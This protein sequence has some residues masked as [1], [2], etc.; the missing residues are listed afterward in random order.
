MLQPVASTAPDTMPTGLIC[1]AVRSM[2]SFTYPVGV[3]TVAALAWEMAT[4]APH[5]AA[6]AAA[7]TFFKRIAPLRPRMKRAPGTLPD[8][9]KTSRESAS[10]SHNP[11]PGCWR[12]EP[13]R[14]WPGPSRPA[15]PRAGVVLLAAGMALRGPALASLPDRTRPGD[16]V[17]GR[18]PAPSAPRPDRAWPRPAARR[19]RAVRLGGRGAGGRRP[20][21][22]DVAARAAAVESP[23]LPHRRLG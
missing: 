7:R 2:P 18:R 19:P 8:S 3:H 13:A 12:R 14:P 10:S 23:P 4:S 16:R 22:L 15:R 17:P 11:H 9:W 21:L 6:A 20:E 1:A 5:A